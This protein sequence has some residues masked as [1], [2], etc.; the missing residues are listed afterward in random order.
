M[1]ELLQPWHLILLFI[2]LIPI[3]AVFG[4]LP[5]WFICRKAGFSP[6]LCLL[7]VIP[8]IGNIALVFLLAFADW[9][10]VP[11]RRKGPA[12]TQP[13]LPRS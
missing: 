3:V 1:G 7:N 12:A 4:V 6:W 10:V 9:R 2:A 11:A 8:L 13:S 5:Y